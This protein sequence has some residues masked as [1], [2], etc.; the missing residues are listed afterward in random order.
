MPLWWNAYTLVLET[1]SARSEGSSPSG[2]TKIAGMAELVDARDS[3]PRIER[4]VGSSPT[5]GT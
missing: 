2:G 3:K 1:S 4:C 5:S